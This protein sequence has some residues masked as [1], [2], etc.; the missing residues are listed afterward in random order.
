MTFC[1]SF[2]GPLT[3]NSGSVD[4]VGLELELT[5]LVTDSLRVDFGCSYLDADY[6]EINPIAGL[7]LTIDE[8]AKLVSVW[9]FTKRTTTGRGN[10]GSPSGTV[11]DAMVLCQSV[12]RIRAS[13]PR[14]GTEVSRLRLQSDSTMAFGWDQRDF[15]ED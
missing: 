12:N 9:D 6:D 5:A 2:G 3:A 10:M 8:S 15:E 14:P 13:R 11:Y 1:D 7:S 4:I